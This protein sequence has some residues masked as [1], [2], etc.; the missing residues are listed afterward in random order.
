MG[1]TPLVTAAST[2]SAINP[3]PNAPSSSSFP[4]E[5][6]LGL[7]RTKPFVTT[8]QIKDHLALLNAFANLRSKVETMPAEQFPFLPSA[9]D[10]RWAWFVGLAVERFEK[11]CK[12]LRPSHTEKGLAMPPLD[13]LMVWHAY[14]L[15]PGWYSEDGNRIN[16]LKGLQAG[17]IAFGAA[18]G[19]GLGERLTRAPSLDRVKFWTQMTSTPFDLLDAPTRMVNRE[20][21]CPKC[22]NVVA[23][24]Y[25][26]NTGSGYLEP[27][28]AMKCTACFFAITRETLAVRKLANDL[29]KSGIIDASDVLAGTLYTDTSLMDLRLARRIKTK[30]LAAQSLKPP[31][32]STCKEYADFLLKGANYKLETLRS[33][34]TA[35]MDYSGRRLCVRFFLCVV[36]CITMAVRIGRIMS[37]YVDD[38]IFSVELVGAVLRQGSFVAKMHGLGWTEPRIFDTTENGVVLEYAIA[39]YHSFLNLM[40]FHPKSFLVPTL[41][42]DLAWHTHQL[43]TTLY[44]SDTARYMYRYIDHNDKVEESLLT[45]SFDETRQKW[46]KE[47]GV[48]YT[49]CTGKILSRVA[50]G[51]AHSHLVPL[52]RQDALAATKPSAHNAVSVSERNTGGQRDSIPPRRRDSNSFDLADAVDIV[53]AIMDLVNALNSDMVNRAP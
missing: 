26:T 21:S 5:F 1:P 23:A 10:R 30:I 16:A 45:N 22:C 44:H 11:W 12:A 27:N 6:K 33:M 36:C 4:K 41:D 37:A 28:F 49:H 34:V 20:I 35:N 25:T 48:D 50:S 42:I 47:Y 15:N 53:N 19:R 9:P 29:A 7:H 18:L 32:T 31:N 38:K 51:G 52:D 24:P 13:V 17:G 2:A 46:R 39:R 40:C 43:L 3:I 14:M 8:A